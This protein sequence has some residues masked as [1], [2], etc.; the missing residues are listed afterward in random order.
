MTIAL[1]LLQASRLSHCD[2]RIVN[3]AHCVRP[4]AIAV[5]IVQSTERGA[6]KEDEGG[7]MYISTL[8]LR[9]CLHCGGH[10]PECINW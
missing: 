1:R 2:C 8:Y 10:Q 5:S 6:V 4:V 9:L 7:Y 3:G